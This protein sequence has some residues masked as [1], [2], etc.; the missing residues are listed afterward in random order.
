MERHSS[1][2][3]HCWA[4]KEYCG[5]EESKWRGV[6]EETMDFGKG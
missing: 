3:D 4:R 1:R 5:K 2:G 6:G